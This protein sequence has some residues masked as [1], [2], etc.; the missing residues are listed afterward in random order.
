MKD[1]AP[2]IITGAADDEYIIEKS[3]VDMS[4]VDYNPKYHHTEQYTE[5]I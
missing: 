4:V 1:I 5:V 2:T 3:V